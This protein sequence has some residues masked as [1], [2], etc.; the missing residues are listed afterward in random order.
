MWVGRMMW[1]REYTID[2]R[3][4]NG[5]ERYDEE[6]LRGEDKGAVVMARVWEH[7]GRD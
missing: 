7:E 2:G 3:K 4:V 1:K 6:S 5:R